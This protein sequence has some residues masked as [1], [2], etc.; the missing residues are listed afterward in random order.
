MDK[1]DQRLSMT[2]RIAVALKLQIR[3]E[4]GQYM[5]WQTARQV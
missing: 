4:P 5:L 2:K 1:N 3:Q